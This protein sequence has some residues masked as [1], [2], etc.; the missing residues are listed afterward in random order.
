MPH[1][2]GAKR[3]W[4]EADS[5]DAPLVERRQFCARDSNQVRKIPTV[6]KHLNKLMT[7]T[8]QIESG[9]FMISTGR[10]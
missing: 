7:I 8:T 9:F 1:I 6:R 2:G 10:H 4:I 3:V 5:R